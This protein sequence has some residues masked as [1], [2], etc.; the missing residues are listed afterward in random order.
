MHACRGASRLLDAAIASTLEN[1][2]ASDLDASAL[3]P[4]KYVDFKEQIRT[5]M[6]SIKQKMN[7][8]RSLHGKVG[9]ELAF[10]LDGTWPCDWIALGACM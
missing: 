7:E 9:P 6:F 2:A 1:G 3:L 4:P 10:Q 5:E 8:L